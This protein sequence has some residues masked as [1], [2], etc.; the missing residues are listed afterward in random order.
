MLAG[1]LVERLRWLP[2]K[3][4]REGGLWWLFWRM[5]RIAFVSRRTT[6]EIFTGPASSHWVGSIAHARNHATLAEGARAI[7][8]QLRRCRGCDFPAFHCEGRIGVRCCPDCSHP[9]AS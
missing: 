2:S 7:V 4:D 8:R 1:P 9:E 5:D 6:G 3:V